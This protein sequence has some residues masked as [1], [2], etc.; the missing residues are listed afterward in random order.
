MHVSQVW[1]D[2]ES[3]FLHS[4]FLE[5]LN[6]AKYRNG[7]EQNMQYFFPVH[8]SIELFLAF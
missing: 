3:F 6:T 1:C 4:D 8:C 5:E 7:K 2:E